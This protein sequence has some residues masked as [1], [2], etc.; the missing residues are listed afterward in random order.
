METPWKV[1]DTVSAV[2]PHCGDLVT[3]RYAHRS[4]RMPRTRLDVGHVLVSVCPACNAVLAMP[5]QSIAQ[6]REIGVGK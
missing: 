1:G 6:L 2:C 5:R 3:A 4:V